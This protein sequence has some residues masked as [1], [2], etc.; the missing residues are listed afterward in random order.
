MNISKMLW[1]VYYWLRSY[2]CV[3]QNTQASV[4]K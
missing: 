4:L 3:Q 1:V 2:F